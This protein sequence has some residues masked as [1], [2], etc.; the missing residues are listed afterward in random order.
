MLMTDYQLRKKILPIVL[1]SMVEAENFSEHP[2]TLFH[3]TEHTSTYT[4]LH[5]TKHISTYTPLHVTK[6]TSTYTPLHV[7][8][9]TSTYTPLHVTKHTS[10][11]TPLHV[12]EHTSTYTPIALITFSLLHFE[13]SSS[14]DMASNALSNSFDGDPI[15]LRT[16]SSRS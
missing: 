8:K 2:C 9:H 11:Y 4:P 5:V 14:A 15:L 6:R 13:G 7:T 12:T 3:V 10:T 16:E 1:T